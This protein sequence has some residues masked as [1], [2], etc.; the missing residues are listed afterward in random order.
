MANRENFTCGGKESARGQG[1]VEHSSIHHNNH[2][3]TLKLLKKNKGYERLL[4][5]QAIR[6]YKYSKDIKVEGPAK[7]AGLYRRWAVALPCPPV[8][9]PLI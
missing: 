4:D 1:S 6:F 2:K 3:N 8:E 9:P 5:K 7:G